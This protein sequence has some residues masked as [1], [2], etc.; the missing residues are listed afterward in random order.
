M[1]AGRQAAGE[2]ILFAHKAY[3]EECKM[4][5]PGGLVE[6]WKIHRTWKA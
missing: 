3:V 6:T 4:H 2:D 5:L 1:R